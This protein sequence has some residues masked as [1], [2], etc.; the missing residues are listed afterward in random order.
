MFY[1]SSKPNP[2]LAPWVDS[3]WQVQLDAGPTPKSE[4]IL[5]NGKIEMIFAL[6]GDY[7]V[8]N[9]QTNK[10][11]Q[12]WLSGIQHEPLHIS[13]K[14]KS[15][16]IGIRFHTYGL[17]PF[18]RIPVNETVNAVE[19]LTDVIGKLYEQL[20][21][22]I[23]QATS[24][25]EVFSIINL[26]LLRNLDHDKVKQLKLMEEITRQ[27]NLRPE[28]PIS[29]LADR[30]GVSQ[31][32]LGRVCHDYM[33]VTPKLLA[34]IFRF[35]KSFSHLYSQKEE[36]DFKA[37]IDLGFYDQSHFIKEFKRFSGMTPAEYKKRAV[38]SNNFL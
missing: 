8:V 20:Y 35:E 15:N 10:I 11:H 30:M 13:Y 31:R 19:P 2:V 32:H 17:F 26:F 22:S 21:E 6:H 5:P 37:L 1:Q 24:S 3:Y 25:V 4:T 14:G 33:G 12:A 18:L 29:Q 9:R 28:Q 38:E 34:R 23:S 27:L 36:E 7:T 16:L